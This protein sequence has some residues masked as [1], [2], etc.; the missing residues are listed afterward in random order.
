M[1]SFPILNFTAG[2]LTL[3][4]T[5]LSILASNALIELSSVFIKT[6]SCGLGILPV[7]PRT[8]PNIVAIDGIS[9]ASAMKKSNSFTRFF[10]SFLSLYFGKSRLVTVFTMLDFVERKAH[11][12]L[13]LTLWGIGTIAETLS[14]L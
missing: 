7:G 4:L 9:F 2:S 1:L 13:S 10:N 5:E 12:F 3:I 14:F 6:P 11:T 8:L